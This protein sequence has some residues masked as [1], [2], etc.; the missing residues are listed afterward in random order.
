MEKYKNIYIYKY[1]KNKLEDNDFNRTLIKKEDFIATEEPLKIYIN[2]N[3][4]SITMRTPDKEED[5]NFVYGYLFTEGIIDSKDDIEKIEF[6]LNEDNRINV[7]LSKQKLRNI[8][9]SNNINNTKDSRYKINQSSCGICGKID[10][11]SNINILKKVSNNIKIEIER[12][13]YLKE[14]F[15]KN[16]KVFKI[17]GS[18]HSASIFDKNLKLLSF[19]ED[20]GR[21]NALDK[22]IGKIIR[23]KENSVNIKSGLILF[24]SSRVS[25]EMV[26]KAIRANIELIVAISS[27]TTFA[28]DLAKRFNVTLIG[29]FRDKG[30]NIYTGK[31]RIKF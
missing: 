28:Y 30:F 16:Q 14:K 3:L 19:S 2:G 12:L 15:E 31:N 23:D 6:C 27:I 17:T 5:F 7:F 9:F 22:A 11:N 24:L 20:I 25:F 4:H 18:M 1:L 21:H 26:T 29:F 13:Y 8:N 10:I